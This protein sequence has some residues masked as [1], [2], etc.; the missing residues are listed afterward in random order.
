[1]ANKS[2]HFKHRPHPFGSIE[3]HAIEGYEM[4]AGYAIT[5]EGDVY[6]SKRRDEFGDWKKLKLGVRKEYRLTIDNVP[7]FITPDQIKQ[8]FNTKNQ[9]Q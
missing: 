7:Y 5:N 6:T 4:Y 8:L 3:L 1:M 2:I 9:N